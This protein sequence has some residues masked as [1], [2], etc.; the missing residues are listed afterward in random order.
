MANRCPRLPA[1]SRSA[2]EQGQ[3]AWSQAPSSGG[4]RGTSAATAGG[5]QVQAAPAQAVAQQPP[6]PRDP[7]LPRQPGTTP[8]EMAQRVLDELPEYQI[9][10]EPPGP[11]RLFRLE[12][13][14]TLQERMRQEAR[15]R[16]TLE[17][18]EFPEEPVLT[19]QAYAP[20]VFPPA[21]EFAEPYYVCYRRLYFEDL[22]S[23][24]YGWDIGFAQPFLSAG[25]FYWDLLTLPYHMG[26]DPCRKFECNAGYCLP[27]DPVPY[28]L[29]PP[30]LNVTGS[31]V[32]AGSIVAL[33]AI[34][35][36]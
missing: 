30:E 14:P 7:L 6:L 19:T 25:I 8:L 18:I 9:Q 15:Q 27:G 32:E 20:R 26:T 36:G 29:Y 34:F 5:G 23:E 10:L 1:P 13:E 21:K 28:L 2:V 22:N 35:P 4:W 24:R 12:S 31:A 17:R 11:E 3:S 16:P 33:F